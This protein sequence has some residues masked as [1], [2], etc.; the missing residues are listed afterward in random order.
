MA[1]RTVLRER[2]RAY[3]LV[4][5]IRDFLANDR[6]WKIYYGRLHE[7]KMLYPEHTKP[8][9]LLLGVTV[10]FANTIYI[11]YRNDVISTLMHECLH[12]IYPRKTEK[13]VGAL[14]RLIMRQM[15]PWQ[16]T[17]MHLLMAKRLKRSF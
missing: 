15:M 12:A 10:R 11:D 2:R 9:D 16:A 5:R 14:Q 13:E 4:R 6:R 17:E 7:C 8:G 1:G 3:R